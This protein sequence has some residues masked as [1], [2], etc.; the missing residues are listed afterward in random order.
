MATNSIKTIDITNKAMPQ[1]LDQP[2]NH[3][4]AIVAK[5]MYR[6]IFLILLVLPKFQ[7]LV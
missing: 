1:E 5:A 7:Y 2:I 4:M 3:E 6:M